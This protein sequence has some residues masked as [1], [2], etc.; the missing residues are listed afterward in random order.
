MPYFSLL[1]ALE[2]FCLYHAYTNRREQ[3][4]YWI[5]LFLPYIGCAIYL[6]DAFYSRRNVASLAEGLKQAVNSDYRLQKLEKQ[7]Q[8]SDNIKNRILLGDAYMEYSRYKDA[9]DMYE[10]C[11]EGYMTDDETLKCKLV[12][13]FYFN[14][15]FDRCIEVGS[16]LRGSKTFRNA[17][18]RVS[19]AWALKMQNRETEAT[20]LF[21]DMDRSYANYPHRF[22]YCQ[23]LIQVGKKELAHEKLAV[24]SEELEHMKGPERRI[25]RETIRNIRDLADK[26]N[27]KPSV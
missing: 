27:S 19:L 9:V 23:F 16:E 25:H 8:F 3:R 2:A 14:K 10:S 11:R 5:I 7:V 6:Y 17:P 20:G 15:Q 13:A 4:W 18:E 1:I 21:E 22:A 24:L 26:M 12:H